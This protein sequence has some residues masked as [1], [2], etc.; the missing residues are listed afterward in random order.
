M[1]AAQPKA[2]GAQ[3]KIVEHLAGAFSD[4]PPDDDTPTYA[5]AGIDKNLA[6]RA[7]RMAP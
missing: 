2:K 6:D 4:D 5:E 1:M 7:R 3:G